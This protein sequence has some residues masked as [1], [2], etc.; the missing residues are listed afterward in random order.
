MAI[1]C[2]GV[3]G[4]IELPTCSWRTM[5]TDGLATCGSPKVMGGDRPFPPAS[6]CINRDGS[7]CVYANHPPLT[8]EQIAEREA[9]RKPLTDGPGAELKIMLTDLGV[10]PEN[11]QCE[12]HAAQMNLWGV[13]GCKQHRL[14]IAAW[15]KEAAA[16]AVTEF[17]VEDPVEAFLPLVD[18]A[19]RRAE[20]KRL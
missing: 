10:S 15:L 2:Y 11:C 19:I 6:V 9:R 14:E 12:Q 3:T 7:P 13:E 17:K 8:P 4:M 5:Q 18:E 20:E 1:N 16:S